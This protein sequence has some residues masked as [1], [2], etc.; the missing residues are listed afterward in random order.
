[1]TKRELVIDCPECG[2]EMLRIGDPGPRALKPFK[3]LRCV[4]YEEHDPGLEERMPGALRRQLTKL[5]AMGYELP[6]YTRVGCNAVVDV[7]GTPPEDVTL[8]AYRAPDPGSDL[9]LERK[10]LKGY[11]RLKLSDRAKLSEVKR[12]RG[13]LVDIPPAEEPLDPEVGAVR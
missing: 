11:A 1:M 10:L 13:R 2:K 6:G 7:M 12:G 4:H 3:L 5:R 9:E 8:V